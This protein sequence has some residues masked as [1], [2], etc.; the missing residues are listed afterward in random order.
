MAMSWREPPRHLPPATAAAPAAVPQPVLCRTYQVFGRV[1]HQIIEFIFQLLK[2]FIAR[3]FKNL[4]KRVDEVDRMRTASH[5]QLEMNMLEK[6]QGLDQKI[7]G[8]DQKI[9]GLDQKIQGLEQKFDTI[10]RK[11]DALIDSFGIVFRSLAST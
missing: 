1:S 7:H 10:D 3:V 4:Q 11:M 2:Y 5:D 6:I 8:L 9:H